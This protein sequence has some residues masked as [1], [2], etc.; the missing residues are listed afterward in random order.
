M[1]DM[2]IQWKNFHVY[3]F[4]SNTVCS[5]GKKIY[6]KNFPLNRHIS[7]H[8]RF[9]LQCPRFW[10]FAKASALQNQGK[11][12]KRNS[13]HSIFEL[14]L[15]RFGEVVPGVVCMT[16]DYRNASEMRLWHI[17]LITNVKEVF[18]TRILLTKVDFQGSGQMMLNTLLWGFW[19]NN[20][21]A[22]GELLGTAGGLP[23]GIAPGNLGYL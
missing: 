1:R 3:F 4:Q 16:L 9:V 8:K 20:A 23:H 14:Q 22:L 6:M 2:T 7:H 18:W 19:G 15:V 11:M 10:H 17:L 13:F 12:T 5:T 21:Q